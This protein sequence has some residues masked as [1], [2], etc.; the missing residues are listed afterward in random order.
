MHLTQWLILALC[1]LALFTVVTVSSG[2]FT[3]DDLIERFEARIFTDAA[4]KT[5]PYRLLQPK[6]YDHKRQY[7]LVLFLHGSGERGTDNAA[8]LSNGATQFA[9]DKLMD[10]YPC[11]VVAPQCPTDKRWVEVDWSL[12]S[13]VMP[14]EPSEPMRLTLLLLKSLQ[15]EFRI[16]KTRIY[17]TGL[18]MGGFGT[19]DIIARHPE[20][21]AAASPVC[22]GGDEATAPLIKNIPIWAFHGDQDTTVKTTRTQHMIAALRKVGAKPHY[23]ELLGV[24][25]DCWD[26]AYANS[27]FYEWMFAQRK[28]R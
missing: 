25:H 6:N 18:S 7:P 11:F 21:F 10:K 16:D 14:V 5:L 22:G 26:Y 1:C 15:Q 27:D 8:Q 23:T 12:D 28:K 2:A 3:K 4:G 19:W 20:L 17:V 13:H 9:T 24:G